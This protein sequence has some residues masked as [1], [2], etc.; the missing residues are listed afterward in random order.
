MSIESVNDFQRK[1]M[2]FVIK[3]NQLMSEFDMEIRTDEDNAETNVVYHQKDV[4]LPAIVANVTA[5]PMGTKK[6]QAYSV[7]SFKISTIKLV[8]DAEEFVK[9]S[10]QI[11]NIRR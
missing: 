10:H 5:F 4:D 9:G 2:A 3:Y 11:S 1:V 7:E 8:V 6:I